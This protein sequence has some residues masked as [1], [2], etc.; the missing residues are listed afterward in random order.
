MQPGDVADL[1]YCSHPEFLSIVETLIGENNREAIA[2]L[3]ERIIR[4]H[5][6]AWDTKTDLEEKVAKLEAKLKDSSKMVATLKARLG[7]NKNAKAA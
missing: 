3:I 6:E 5:A 2:A 7:E 1:Y 4:E